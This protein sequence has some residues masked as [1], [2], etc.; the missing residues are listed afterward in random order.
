MAITT[1]DSSIDGRR[2]LGVA[3][4]CF[5]EPEHAEFTAAILSIDDA[6][7]GAPNFIETLMVIEARHREPGGWELDRITGNLG[8][9]IVAFDAGHVA[10]AREGFRRFGKG[11]HYAALNFGDRCTY[12]LAKMLDIPLLF[13]GNDFSLI[14]VK[15]AL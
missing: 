1:R 9:S 6:R 15:P 5:E 3:A 7:M 8:L 4:I 11:R 14:D 2:Q 12:A 13:K 10:A